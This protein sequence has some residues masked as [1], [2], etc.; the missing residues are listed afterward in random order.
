TTRAL[1][2]APVSILRGCPAEAGSFLRRCATYSVTTTSKMPAMARKPA[3]ANVGST[4]VTERYSHG[5]RLAC[6]RTTVLPSRSTVV[7]RTCFQ[8]QVTYSDPT[9]KPI[10]VAK[11]TLW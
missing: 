2:F 3:A 6:C 7:D 5:L 10:R 9:R 8:G 11:V 4:P 1:V